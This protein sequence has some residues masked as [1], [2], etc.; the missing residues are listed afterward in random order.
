MKYKAS[1]HLHTKED[2]KDDKIIKY[3]IYD[4]INEAER[5]NFKI[6]ALTGHKYFLFKPE[7]N[8]YAQ[9]KGILLIPGI[10]A[11]IKG[12]HCLILNCD[13][14]AEQI[15]TLNDL[16]IYKQK[17]PTCLIIAPHPNY[18]I[19]SLGLKLIE[20]YSEIFD[21]IEHSWFYSKI[22]NPNI[23]TAKL[24]KKIKKPLIATA[25]L[26]Q[27]KYLN[28]NYAL[29]DCPQLD[30]ISVLEAIKQGKFENYS[31]PQSVLNMFIYFFRLIF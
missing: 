23:A 4:L 24:A 31:Q 18:K 14:S 8:D 28:S 17:H 21:A 2:S 29:I 3:S 25:D 1:L 6:L 9:K 7:Y 27:L 10:E 12:R 13:K 22:I 19:K 5:F 20:K 16:I 11:E 26:H 15:K 30:I